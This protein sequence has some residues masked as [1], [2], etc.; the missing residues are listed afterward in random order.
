MS[1]LRKK[2]KVIRNKRGL[3]QDDLAELSKVNLRTIQRI[4]NN[5]TVP[6]E[7]TL[8]LIYNALD[9]EVMECKKPQ[10][11][12]YL[13]W[14]SILTLLIIVGTFIG[15]FR[16]FKMYLDGERVYNTFTGWEGYV[17]FNDYNFHNWLLSISA[18]SIG[19][20]AISHSF[21]FIKNKFK[22]VVFQFLILIFYVCAII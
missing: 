21:G 13:I 3:S 18:I 15:W 8:R 4:E 17:N 6:R 20:I 22:Y 9:I 12:K 14:S 2:I 10:I 11:N 19:I 16:H 5:E 7:K 1:E